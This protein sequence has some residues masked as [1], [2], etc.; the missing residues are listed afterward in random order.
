[1]QGDILNTFG[2][3]YLVWE[4]VLGTG[5]PYFHLKHVLIEVQT[6]M[7]QAQLK[8]KTI[9]SA[10]PACNIQQHFWSDRVISSIAASL[11]A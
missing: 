10:L 8:K 5:V 6:S 1:L 11:L 3:R 2:T 9:I 4:N 7:K